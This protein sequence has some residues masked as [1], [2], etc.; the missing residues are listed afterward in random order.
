MGGGVEAAEAHG[1]EAL[2]LANA[3]VL[4]GEVVSEVSKLKQQTEGEIVVYASRTARA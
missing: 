3:T 1:A 4:R 2:L